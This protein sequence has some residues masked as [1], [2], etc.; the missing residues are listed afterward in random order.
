MGVPHEDEARAAVEALAGSALHGRALVVNQARPRQ[1]ARFTGSGI[2]HNAAMGVRTIRQYC[3]LDAGGE[4]LL[5]QAMPRFG[6]SARAHYRI[7]EVAR[8][9]ADLAGEDEIGIEHLSEA[10]QYPTLDREARY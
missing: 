6:L 4:R 10:V 2:P 1:L 3:Q 8:I 7:R 5:E 9:I